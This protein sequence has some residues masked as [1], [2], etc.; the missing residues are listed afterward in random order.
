[1]TTPIPARYF[2]GWDANRAAPLDAA[3]LLLYRSNLLGSD[4]RITN[5]G[6]DNTSAQIWPT[7]PLPGQ[8]VQVLRPKGSGGD[9]GSRALDGCATLYTDKWLALQAIS[10]G[11]G[12]VD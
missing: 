11:P 9:L 4:L 1:M 12:H 3:R 8:Q 2:P 6:G 5:Y 7:H 10:R